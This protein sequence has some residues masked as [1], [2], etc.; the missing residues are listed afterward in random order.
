[1]AG[2]DRTGAASCFSFGLSAYRYCTT[3]CLHSATNNTKTTPL[4]TYLIPG[5]TT[6]ISL[7]CSKT[8]CTCQPDSPSD[9]QN[10]V[11]YH[12]IQLKIK[13][14]MLLKNRINENHSFNM[15]IIL[16]MEISSTFGAL[17]WFLALALIHLALLIQFSIISTVIS[18]T[19]GKLFRSTYIC[20]TLNFLGS[21]YFHV[22]GSSQIACNTVTQFLH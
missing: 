6:H 21:G 15:W 22:L 9:L 10:H 3:H 2:W 13:I 8:R 12:K 1:M 11:L 5:N 7:T 18:L 14:V 17:F 19:L 20:I 4:P 16:S